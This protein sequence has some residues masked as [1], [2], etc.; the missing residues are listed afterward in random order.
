LKHE[1]TIATAGNIK[2]IYGYQIQAY[3]CH[4]LRIGA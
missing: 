3:E 1:N 2:A 4:I